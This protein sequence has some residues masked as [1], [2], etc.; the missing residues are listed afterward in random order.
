MKIVLFYSFILFRNSKKM[1]YFHFYFYS[2]FLL[3]LLLLLLLLQKRY[4][5][6]DPMSVMFFFRNRHIMVDF[7]TGYLFIYL[8][9]LLYFN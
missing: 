1:Y 5:L 4:E 2:Y 6:Y 9:L 3:L 7:G 8:L